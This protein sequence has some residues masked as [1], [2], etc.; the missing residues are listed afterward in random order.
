MRA[1]TCCKAQL[2]HISWSQGFTFHLSRGCG[3]GNVVVPRKRLICNL[4]NSNGRAKNPAQRPLLLL[5]LS[6]RS[7]EG[8]DRLQTCPFYILF[9]LIELPGVGCHGDV[10]EKELTFMHGRRTQCKSSSPTQERCYTGRR[11]KASAHQTN[12]CQ[13]SQSFP[14]AFTFLLVPSAPLTLPRLQEGNLKP[15]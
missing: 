7:F 5:A 11:C 6:P 15:D 14:D 9:S 3:D 2:P 10:L 8:V 1:L 4:K 12:Q 13:I